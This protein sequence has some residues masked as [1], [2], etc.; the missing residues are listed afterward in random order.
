VEL[1]SLNYFAVVV[2]VGSISAAAAALHMTQ[3]A[4]SRQLALLERELGQR[5]VTR[6]PHGVV[7]TAAGQ[8][9]FEHLRSVFFHIDR[10]SEVVRTAAAGDTLID[11]GLPPGVPEDWFAA[12]RE[13]LRESSPQ[14]RMSLHEASTDEQRV[15]LR[16]GVIELGLLHAGPIGLETEVMLMQRL[17]VVVRANSVLAS[18][19]TA[20]FADLGGLRVLAHA[21]GEVSEEEVRLRNAANSANAGVDWVFRRFSEHA[22][23][24]A[25]T[26]G[27]DAVLITRVSAEKHL[28]GWR[29]IPLGSTME[30]ETERTVT[31]WAAWAEPQSAKVRAVLAAMR[32]VRASRGIDA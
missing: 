1:R 10:I 11:I 27:A 4:L 23:L 32:R 24:I 21:S 2:E 17:G 29:W 15:M 9:L 25:E 5:L 14:V 19:E 13:E 16:E 12:L 6:T 7:P 22:E 26:S 28:A 31:T 8:G 20:T 3:P 18:A 30:T